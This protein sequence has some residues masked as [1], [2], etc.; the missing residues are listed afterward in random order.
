MN[1]VP[2]RQ[3]HHPSGA[4]SPLP[5]RFP[6]LQR[7][8]F[9]V[10]ENEVKSGADLHSPRSPSSPH[11]MV[12]TCHERQ[13]PSGGLGSSS[14][15]SPPAYELTPEFAEGSQT[16]EKR[17]SGRRR[18]C[19]WIIPTCWTLHIITL[20]A[21]IT[22]VG[23][24]AQALRSH[25]KLRQIR[26]FNGSDSAWPSDMSLTPSIVLLSVG[27]TSVV[28]CFICMMVEAQR[29]TRLQ[30]PLFL[31]G[32]TASSAAMAAFWLSAA[33]FMETKGRNSDD[34]ATWACARSD[35]A[36]NQI[37]PYRTIC[38]EVVGC[39]SPTPL[40]IADTQ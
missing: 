30:S 25:Q 10:P 17:D 13:Q 35:A 9:T 28:K 3:D 34:F 8:L 5:S 12:R 36:V 40:A 15:E 31:L 27:A 38:N 20:A 6:F 19:G 2:F 14:S 4:V 1:Y 24:L 26:Q 39:R 11:F 21:S 37:V 29:R 18:A 16:L 32:L 7:T 23:L 33:I 22:I